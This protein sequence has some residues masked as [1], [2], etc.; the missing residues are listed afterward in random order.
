MKF[1]FQLIRERKP[2]RL[3]LHRQIQRTNAENDQIF[4]IMAQFPEFMALD[5]RAEILREAIELAHLEICHEEK[6]PGCS[7]RNFIH[8][9]IFKS[10]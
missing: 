10:Y 8:N 6:Q 1:E 2:S 5:P 3:L 9:L 7:V 4:Q